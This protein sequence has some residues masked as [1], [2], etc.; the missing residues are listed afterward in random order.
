WTC[1]K[2]HCTLIVTIPPNAT[3]L[4]YVPTTD[5]EKIK[6]PSAPLAVFQRME[7]PYALFELSSGTHRFE[8]D[9]PK[10]IM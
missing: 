6:A 2:G 1:D 9:L 10:S 8:S 7:G 4:L 3:G 5:P